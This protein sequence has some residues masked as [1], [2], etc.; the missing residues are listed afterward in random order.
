MGV[1][2]ITLAGSHYVSRMSTAVLAGANMP[3]WIAQDRSGYIN[4]AVNMR[5][6]FRSCE[7]IVTLASSASGQSVG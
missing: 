6:V 4:L 7:P 2:T 1:P 3:E 5:R